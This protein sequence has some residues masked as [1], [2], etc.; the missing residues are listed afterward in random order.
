MIGCIIQARLNSSRLPGKIMMKIDNEKSVLDYVINQL[1]FCK[2]IDKIVIATTT[3]VYDDILVEYAKSHHLD[4]FQGN[5]IDVLDRYYK[6]AKSFSFDTI[7]RVTSDCPLVDP[8]VVD[9]LIEQFQKGDFDY[10]TNKLP[11]ESSK[12]PHGSEVEVFSFETLKRTWEESKKSSE[13]EHVTPYIYNS[14]DKFKI[15]K[16][17]SKEDLSYMRYTVD[18]PK[19]LVMIQEI[20]ARIKTRPILTKDIVQLFNE[21]PQLLGIN[22][23]YQRNEGYLRSLR[24]EK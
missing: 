14:S 17:S 11:L 5:E 19:D 20:T 2:H 18:R 1:K 12:C 21:V 3:S 22:S 4:F 13:R 15:C 7:V 23:E 10:A 16:M 9:E 6:C 8:N 24:D